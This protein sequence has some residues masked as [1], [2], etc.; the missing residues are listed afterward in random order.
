VYKIEPSVQTAFETLTCFLQL[1]ST[2]LL[3]IIFEYQSFDFLTIEEILLEA[4]YL[5]TF[6]YFTK[7]YFDDQTKEEIAR[8]RETG[9]VYNI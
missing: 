7:Y 6:K 2:L 9:N 1:T 3:W 4:V 8:K 5:R